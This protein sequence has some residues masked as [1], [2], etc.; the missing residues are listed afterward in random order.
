MLNRKLTEEVSEP[1]F[2]HRLNPQIDWRSCKTLWGKVPL[3]ALP[4]CLLWTTYSTERGMNWKVLKIQMVQNFKIFNVFSLITPYTLPHI[5][6]IPYFTIVF[7]FGVWFHTRI[8]VLSCL[9]FKFLN[10][11]HMFIFWIMY[12]SLL[13]KLKCNM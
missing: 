6:D 7:T 12:F 4:S 2:I 8:G 9:A 13:V 3:D 1:D 11:T 5:L 10:S